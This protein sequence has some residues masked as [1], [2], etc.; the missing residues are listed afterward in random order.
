MYSQLALVFDHPLF[1]QFGHVLRKGA[2]L[3]LS[4]LDDIIVVGLSQMGWSWVWLQ[5]LSTLLLTL[6][7]AYWL[8][9]IVRYCA[10]RCA[11]I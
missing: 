5:W 7:V 11:Q 1:S 9:C 8:Y 2:L 10:D 4:F 6:T 3:A